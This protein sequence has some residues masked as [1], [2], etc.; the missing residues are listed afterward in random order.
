MNRKEENINL[1]IGKVLMIC[2]F[3]LII[4]AFKS[5]DYSDKYSFCRNGRIINVID[6]DKSA[7]LDKSAIL[8]SQISSKDFNGSIVACKI[9]AFNI[10]NKNN[11]LIICSNNKVNQLLKN[12]QERFLVIKPQVLDFDSYHIRTS[13]NNEEISLIS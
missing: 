8:V 1:L 3:V 13:L 6:V 7:N 2:L 10:C 11:F 9:F 12:C 4:F 5:T